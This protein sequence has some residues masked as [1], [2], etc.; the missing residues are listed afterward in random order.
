MHRPSALIECANT[1]QDALE[2]YGNHAPVM[3]H[4]DLARVGIPEHDLDVY[5]HCIVDG[6][7][8]RTLLLPTFN[9]DYYTNR[10]FDVDADPCQVGMLN[11]YA[12][13]TAGV[14][15]TRQPVYS[16]ACI[17]DILINTGFVEN[18]L[19]QQSVFADLVMIDGLVVFWGA[20]FESCTF[21]HHIEEVLCIPYRRDKEFPGC[22]VRGS[23]TWNVKMHHKV[24]PKNVDIE[25][26]WP[27]LESELIDSG[28]LDIH[29]LG[30][31]RLRVFNAEIV[32][33]FWASKVKTD[34]LYFLTAESRE[35]SWY[36][37]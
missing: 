12:R 21:L 11:E 1:L 13:R 8:G 5:L 9:Y 14:I 29:P 24:R 35:M 37:W 27:R 7:D 16:F 33:K 6:C 18:P 23:L 3:M 4:T 17:G 34:P 32:G 30:R 19:G 10:K 15:R 28:H 2:K 20:G 31:G 22:V 26:D 25:I 36:A